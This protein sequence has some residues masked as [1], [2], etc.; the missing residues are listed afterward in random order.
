MN[1]QKEKVLIIKTGYSEFL[2]EEKDSRITSYGDILRTTALLHIYKNDHVTWVTD[3]RAFPLLEGNPYIDKLLGYDF[4]TAFQLISEEFD[5]VIN[6]EK[7]PGIC[8]LSDRIHT[9]K[10]RY[11]FTFNTQTGNVEA[12]D[13]ASKA[14]AI[15]TNSTLKRQNK[16]IFHELLFEMLG[17]KWKKEEFMLGYQSKSEEVYDVGLN[18]TIGPKWPTKRWLGEYWNTLEELL[19]KEGFKV[20]RQDSKE[21]KKKGILHNLEKYIDWIN[22][23]RIIVSSDTLG[24]HLGIVLK[25]KVLGLFG[26]SPSREVYFY[27]RGKAIFPEPIPDCLPCFKNRCERGKNC[28]EDISPEKV[29]EEVKTLNENRD[30]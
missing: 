11:G 1:E 14:L 23:S 24:L 18:T 9:R 25:K 27:G 29:Y 7:V 30:R 22:S 13:G 21:N 28:M 8:A 15:G 2:E 17:K 4:T 19:L 3:K 12:L 5:R 6:L 16:K 10:S 20:T 26:P